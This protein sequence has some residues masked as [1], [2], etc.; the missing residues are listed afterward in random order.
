[1]P[2][3]TVVIA[4]Y[5]WSS[6]LPY[7]IASAL[8][9]TFSDFELLVVGDGCT[10]ESEAVVGAIRDPRL[11]WINIPRVGHQSG[12]NNEGI[13][14]ARGRYIAYLGHDDLW[15]PHHLQSLVTALDAGADV[16]HTLVASVS[17]KK[18]VSPKTLVPTCVAHTRALAERIG[19]WRDYRTLSMAPERDLWSRAAA[20]GARFTAVARLTAVKIP[21]GPRQGV[22]RE[23]PSHEQAAWLARIRSERDLE[24]VLLGSWVLPMV[25]AET[26]TRRMGRFLLAPWRWPGVVLRLIR[27]RNGAEIRKVQR[28]KGVDG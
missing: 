21:A 12:P 14:Q 7:S 1:M 5:N 23:R 26:A 11:R 10:D 24:A 9:Q 18:I 16:A 17:V 20:A 8:E 4:T 28:F 25:G 6:V 3:I 13:R 27:R 2:R 22:Y 15:L 19:G